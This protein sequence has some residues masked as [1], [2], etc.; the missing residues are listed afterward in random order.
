MSGRYTDALK[1]ADKEA[2]IAAEFGLTFVTPYAELNRACAM[3]AL[4]E[5]GEARRALSIVERRAQVSADPFLES[6][7]AVQSAV[8]AISK[9][10]LVRAT[11]HLARGSHAR[12]TK[13]GR[14]AHHALH[15][16][17]LSAMNRSEEAEDE[18]RSALTLSQ[19]VET[20]ALLAAGAAIRAAVRG[21]SA[22]CI[23]AYE[24]AAASGAVYAL[25]LAWR[26]RYEVAATL[27]NSRKHRDA[28]LQLLLD[29]NDTAIAKRSGISLPRIADRR[30]GLSARE[31]EVCELLAQGR[32]NQE[33]A[34]M[35][36]ISLSTTKV[37]VKHILEKLGVRS[38][39]EAGRIWEERSS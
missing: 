31:Q 2:A 6:Q 38:R 36:F 17:V 37:H 28:V 39:V 12:T 8:L 29:A 34:T 19:T 13:P 35:L 14:G 11:D 23:R 7:H 32:T 1:A 20:R 4:R 9:G 24:E 25:M 10:D 3:T 30:L 22:T 18:V 26:A 27:L 33:I 5:F 16:L 21:D 15:A